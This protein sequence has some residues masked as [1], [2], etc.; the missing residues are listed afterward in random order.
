MILVMENIKVKTFEIGRNI[1]YQM[2][3]GCNHLIIYDSLKILC[4]AC[5]FCMTIVACPD[6]EEKVFA[7][8]RKDDDKKNPEL[9]LCEECY[10]E[11]E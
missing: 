2:C 8:C 4:A 7:K 1:E 6:C 9:E 11:W 10:D 5:E 3:N